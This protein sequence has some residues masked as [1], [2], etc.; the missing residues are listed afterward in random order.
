MFGYPDPVVGTT[1][2]Y[3]RKESIPVRKSRRP[4]S[5]L[6]FIRVLTGRNTCQADVPKTVHPARALLRVSKGAGGSHECPV[7]TTTWA[8]AQKCECVYRSPER[9][10]NRANEFEPHKMRE[11]GTLLAEIRY[12]RTARPGTGAEQAGAD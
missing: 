4:F 2:T 3:E 10:S 12:P 8:G 7:C 5:V 11:R 9:P 6:R 1:P